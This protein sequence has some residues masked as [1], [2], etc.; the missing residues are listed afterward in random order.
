MRI[1]R[2]WFAAWL[3]LASLAL[4]REIHVNNL[5][6]DDR[7]D[8]RASPTIAASS[9]P[10]RS[11]AK[12]LRLAE[13]GD[14][15]VVANTSQPYRESLSLTNSKHSG[16]PISPFVIE[17]DGAVLEGAAELPDRAWKH[18]DGDVFFCQPAGLGYQ[19]LF[20]QG[21]PANRRSTID[22]DTRVPAL[23]PLEWCLAE[24][25]IYFRV[26][27]GQLPSDYDLACCALRTGITLYNVRDVVI[28][29]LVIQGFQFDG[30]A[31]SNVV[32]DARLEGVT[33]RANGRSGISVCGGSSVELADCVLSGNGDSQLQSERYSRSFIHK[34]KLI[35]D[36]APAIMARG[37]HIAIDGQ[38][39]S[40]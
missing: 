31:A 1:A 11:I 23:Q 28:R 26:E 38:L 34:S 8:G 33:C 2:R 40:E 7:S 22:A 37:G 36:T 3:C 19:Q 18:Y 21:R 25:R 16:S 30:I 17:G 39:L 6:G 10:V 13:A 4:G 35:A 15:I 32:V 29:N 12:A 5:E 14:R 20:S 24:S 27:A 9:G